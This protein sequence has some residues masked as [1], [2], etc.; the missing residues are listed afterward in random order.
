MFHPYCTAP[1]NATRDHSVCEDP[2]ASYSR[3]DIEARGTDRE[4]RDKQFD[5]ALPNA[6]HASTG[7]GVD[8]ADARD[9]R[10][11]GEDGEG[12]FGRREWGLFKPRRCYPNTKYNRYA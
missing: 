5:C 8:W 12:C 6:E 10:F 4:H 9:C 7:E 3:R 2:P 11:R 1:S